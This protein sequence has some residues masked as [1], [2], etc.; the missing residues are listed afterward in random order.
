V[1]P[2]AAKVPAGEGTRERILYAAAELFR[3]QGYSGTGIKQ[4]A[5]AADAQL[6]SIYHFYPGGKEELAERVIETAGPF[7]AALVAASMEPAPDD[8]VA[9][10]EAFFAGAAENVEASGYQDACPIAT[11]ALEVASTSERLRLATAGAFGEWID[12]IAEWLRRLG[13]P[14]AELRPL[15][16]S[17]LAALEGG[18]VLARATRS[19]EPLEA[20]GRSMAAAMRAALAA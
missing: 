15:A 6:G 8:P 14:E 16:T 1:S 3:R 18:F 7:F 19:T 10:V 20:A 17:L 5:A 9:W 11:V 12:A 13:V 2:A 4:I